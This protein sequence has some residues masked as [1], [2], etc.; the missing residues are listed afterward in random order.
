MSKKYE[1]SS[2]DWKS[3]WLYLLSIFAVGLL[4][5]LAW[6]EEILWDFFNPQVTTLL[7]S[8]IWIALKKFLTDY[9]K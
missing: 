2:Y 4:S 3:I 8:F 7:I 1:L 9:S 5:N 6:L